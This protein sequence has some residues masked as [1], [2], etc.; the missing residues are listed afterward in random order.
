MDTA[1]SAVQAPSTSSQQNSQTEIVNI[2]APDVNS[3]QLMAVG[4]FHLTCLS[5]EWSLCSTSVHIILL[6]N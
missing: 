1:V 4:F 3:R 6:L 5:T 2:L